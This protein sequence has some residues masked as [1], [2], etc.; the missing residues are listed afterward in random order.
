MLF[1]FQVTPIFV[2]K[3]NFLKNLVNGL[4]VKW[5]KG[6]G[7]D[8][9]KFKI[10]IVK[11]SNQFKVRSLPNVLETQFD[12][13]EYNLSDIFLTQDYAVSRIRFSSAPYITLDELTYL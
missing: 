13:T 12:Q 1:C 6:T 11:D 10:A 8:D 3:F 2:L 4:K 7:P 9:L 5:K